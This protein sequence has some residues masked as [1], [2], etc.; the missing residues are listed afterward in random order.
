MQV[1]FPF[2]VSLSNRVGAL[3]LRNKFVEDLT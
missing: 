3:I 1:E 2:V